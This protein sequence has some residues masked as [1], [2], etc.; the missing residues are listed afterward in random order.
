[1]PQLHTIQRPPKGQIA[2]TEGL[3][4]SRRARSAIRDKSGTGDLGS[5]RLSRHPDGARAEPSAIPPIVGEVLRSSGQPLDRPTR[6]VMSERFGHD[7]SAVR[8]HSD[9]RAGRSAKA[10][11]ASAY[12]V[13]PHIVFA[14]GRY[15]PCT[16]QGQRLLAHELTHVVQQGP[17]ATPLENLRIDPPSSAAEQE[18]DQISAGVMRAPTTTMRPASGQ[19]V[20]SRSIGGAVGFGVV[21]SAGLATAGA[22]IGSQASSGWGVAG[23]ILGGV[24]GLIGGAIVGDLITRKSRP[25]TGAEKLEARKIFQGS[26]DYEVITIT[27]NGALAQD[28][29]PRT[30][31]NTIHLTDTCFKPGTMDLNDTGQSTLIHEMVHVWQYQHG[32]PSYISSSLVAQ[33]VAKPRP[34]EKKPMGA[35]EWRDLARMRMAWRQWNAEQQA[36]CITEY[37]DAR[38]RSEAPNAYAAE[39]DGE[40]RLKDVETMRIVEPYLDLIRRGVGAP[41]SEP[42]PGEVGPGS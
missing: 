40:Q 8:V 34:G 21:G 5:R 15:S 31:K 18:A 7:F 3:L 17:P 32:G 14:P 29:R 25:L 2:W 6:D 38:R 11:A 22:A 16:E 10:V 33:A 27:K 20:L 23:G 1:M 36:E 41:G 9:D 12:T 13:A 19:G 39:K 28:G 35:Y 24:A 37:N 42:T 4:P 26:V 30:F